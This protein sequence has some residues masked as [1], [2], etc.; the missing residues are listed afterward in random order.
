MY[1]SYLDEGWKEKSS[2]SSSQP[3]VH[4]AATSMVPQPSQPRAHRYFNFGTGLVSQCSLHSCTS[5]ELS[6]TVPGGAGGESSAASYTTSLSTDTLYWD[7]SCEVCN[8]MVSTSFYFSQLKSLLFYIQHLTELCNTKKN[9]KLSHECGFKS[10]I[11]SML[12]SFMKQEY[13]FHCFL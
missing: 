9:L 12:G 6:C 8:R 10:C 4:P 3:A 1:I 11:L 5:S 7:P 13:V 2:R